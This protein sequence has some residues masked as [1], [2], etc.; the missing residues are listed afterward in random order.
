MSPM[1]VAA[2]AADVAL[3]CGD[4]LSSR[5][6]RQACVSRLTKLDVPLSTLVAVMVCRSVICSRFDVGLSPL[7]VV[8]PGAGHS[9]VVRKPYHPQQ[10]LAAPS[11]GALSSRSP[12]S[13]SPR[14]LPDSP[15]K[16]L[17]QLSAA[18]RQQ[19]T[20]QTLQ[21]LSAFFSSRLHDW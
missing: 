14:Q 20:T 7:G 1:M 3:Y 18:H 15:R 2:A 12:V 8:E 11:R 5:K 9:L 6:Q 10:G 21:T 13:C 17:L 16:C 4:D 19:M